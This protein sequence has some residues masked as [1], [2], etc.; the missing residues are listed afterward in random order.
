MKNKIYWFT[1]QPGSGKTTLGLALCKNYVNSDEYFFLDGDNLRT[2]TKNFDYTKNGRMLNIKNAQ[3]ISSYL[4]SLNK[5]VIVAM[6]SPYRELRENFKKEFSL[7]E[8]YLTSTRP[9]KASYHTDEYEAPLSNFLHLDTDLLTI[10]ECI[11]QIIK[12]S[13]INTINGPQI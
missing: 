2:I 8:I 5:D 7:I 13:N 4:Y 11:N 9:T 1:G 12:Y 3:T 6:V 10:P